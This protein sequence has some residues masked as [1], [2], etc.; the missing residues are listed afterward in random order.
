MGLPGLFLGV[1]TVTGALA[2]AQRQRAEEAGPGNFGGQ[3]A[4]DQLLV[5]NNYVKALE[6]FAHSPNQKILMLPLKASAVIGALGGI[7]EIA[8]EAFG[9]S[10]PAG[11]PT[12]TRRGSG[13]VPPVAPKN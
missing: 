1:A 7:T 5:A 8:R 3:C 10:P 2:A 4:S 9:G 6:A 13:T 12:T 11:T